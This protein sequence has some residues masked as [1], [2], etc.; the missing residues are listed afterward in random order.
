MFNFSNCLLI[1]KNMFA[2]D[3]LLDWDYTNKRMLIL[4]I[5]IRLRLWSFSVL[6]CLHHLFGL[7]P[8]ATANTYYII[9]LFLFLFLFPF[10]FFNV[11][12]PFFEY[13]KPCKSHEAHKY[14]P[15]YHSDRYSCW[16]NCICFTSGGL[17]I[18][19]FSFNTDTS[20][21]CWTPFSIL[22][23]L[24]LINCLIKVTLGKIISLASRQT[25][26]MGTEPVGICLAST[27]SCTRVSWCNIESICTSQGALSQYR[28]PLRIGSTNTITRRLRIHIDRICD[29][30]TVSVAS[31]VKEIPVESWLTITTV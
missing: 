15:S 8:N 30:E 16:I 18:E 31:I 25:F 2:Y 11:L 29:N 26:E 14:C 20:I 28:V 6:T 21:N 3:Q 10:A 9:L 19:N 4:K 7:D 5:I 23:T 27:L 1:I 13:F 24:A 12:L 22:N 17:S